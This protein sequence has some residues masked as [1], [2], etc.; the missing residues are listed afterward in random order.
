MSSTIKQKRLEAIIRRD[1]SEII[2]YDV[3]DPNV[4]FLTVTDVKVSNDHSY[5]TI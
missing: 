3:K 4:G 1:I 5:A 2:Q